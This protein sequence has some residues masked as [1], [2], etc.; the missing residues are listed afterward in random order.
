MKKNVIFIFTG[1]S[2]IACIYFA[3]E[4]FMPALASNKYIEIELPK[5]TTFRQA[6]NIL[7][8]E[9]LIRDKNIFILLGKLTGSDKKIRAGFYSIWG[10]MSPLEIFR[11]LRTGQIIEYEIKIL[12]G[13]SIF[14]IADKLSEVGIMSKE[15]FMELS[16]NSSFLSYYDIYA[17]SIEG[18][19]F[20]DTYKIPKGIDPEDAIGSMID[21]MREKYSGELYPRTLEMGMTENEVLTLASI[22]EKEAVIDSERPLISGVYHNRLKKN[23]PLQ[24]DPTAVY[25]VKSSR[26]KITKS[27]LIRKSPYNTYVIK[28]LPPGPIASPGLK[29]IIAAL[30]PADIP[31]LYFVSKDDVTHYFSSTAE[32]H[33]KAVKLY[34]EKKQSL[35][36]KKKKEDPKGGST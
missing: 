19:I 11:T 10:I 32:E 4:L 34:R 21:R 23:M 25:G 31:Y 28:G 6:V 36:N 1:I 29:S 35:R 16:K 33:L 24:A 17:D 18:Y 27:D 3:T 2:L 14:E 5:G 9:K 7:A 30:Y 8:K 15:D 12:E 20:P 26:E 13:N 22:I